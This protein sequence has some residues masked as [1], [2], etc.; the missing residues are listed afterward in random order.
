MFYLTIIIALLSIPFESVSQ[1]YTVKKFGYRLHALT[2]FLVSSIMVY[3]IYTVFAV[4][5]Y[6]F[7]D[8]NKILFNF[9]IEMS[10]ASFIYIG[11]F[12]ANYVACVVLFNKELNNSNIYLLELLVKLSVVFISIIEILRGEVALTPIL[13]LG[14]FLFLLGIFII[15]DIKK[16]KNVMKNKIARASLIIVI[17]LVLLNVAYPYQLQHVLR[18]GY[19]DRSGMFLLSSVA[20]SLYA[21]LV[22]RP[23]LEKFK[24][25]IAPYILQAGLFFVSFFATTYLVEIS[26][27]AYIYVIGLAGIL[28]TLSSSIILKNNIG[29]RH[30]IGVSIS[31]VG[32]ILMQLVI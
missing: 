4:V 22:L 1:E 25:S 2:R 23:N 9:Q 6:G 7:S 16:F 15:F 31:L 20:T 21:L 8:F 19:T 29:L 26:V 11:L 5:E 14:T 32:F 28:L 17:L 10:V 30:Y 18:S 13:V 24:E 3:F 27:L 12:L